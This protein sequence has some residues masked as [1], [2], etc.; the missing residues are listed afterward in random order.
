[1]TTS[2]LEEDL[3]RIK[4]AIWGLRGDNGLVSEVKGLRQAVE[5]TNKRIDDW[6]EEER[7]RRDAEAKEKAAEQK[8]MLDQRK[9][10]RRWWAVYAVSIVVAIIAAAGLI[11][12]AL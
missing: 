5:A 8:A 12:N 10:D 11:A 1:M 4:Y 3:Q 2:E 9:R 7:L 6:R